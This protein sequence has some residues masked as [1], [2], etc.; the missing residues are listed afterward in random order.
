VTMDY[1]HIGTCQTEGIHAVSLKLGNQILVQFSQLCTSS[2]I[3]L[4]R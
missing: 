4:Q 2:V 3:S 1:V